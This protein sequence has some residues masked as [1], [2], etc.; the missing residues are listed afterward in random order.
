MNMESVRTGMSR[1]ATWVVF[2]A[3]LLLCPALALAQSPKSPLKNSSLA[4]RPAAK[5]ACVYKAV[6]SDPEIEACTGHKVQYDYSVHESRR[7][8]SLDRTSST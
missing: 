2:S 5:S 1:D 8:R 3:A 7:P 6:M 4:N